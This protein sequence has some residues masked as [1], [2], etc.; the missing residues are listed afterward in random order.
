MNDPILYYVT[1]LVV[2]GTVYA[3]ACA[4]LSLQF[5]VTGVVNFAYIVFQAAGAYTAAI[6]TLGPASSFGFQHY[7]GGTH[8]PFPL[9]LVAAMVVGAVMSGFVAFIG[10][11]NLRA[12]YL[13]IALLVCSLIATEVAEGNR[14][15]VNGATGLALIPQPLLGLFHNNPQ[16]LSWR[17]VYTGIALLLCVGCYVVVHR[18]TESPY[19]RRL[20]AL[21]ENEPAAQAQGISP[22]RSQLVVL[23]VGGAMAGL[24]GGILVEFIGAWAPSSWLYPETFVFF[25]ALIIGGLGNNWGAL[26]GAVLLPLAIGEG[27]RYL[28]QFGSATLTVALQ[29]I[30]IGALPLVFMWFRPQGIIPERRRTVNKSWLPELVPG[31]GFTTIRREKTPA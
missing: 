27:V 21:R 20:R 25:V 6:V 3:I 24:S 28:P 11:R 9:P 14:G 18:I 26:L 16:S 8:W 19:G 17:L 22:F 30:V 29:W 23:V 5:A 13:A 1:L 12:D 10:I 15:L 31:V 2:Y 4:G 7:I